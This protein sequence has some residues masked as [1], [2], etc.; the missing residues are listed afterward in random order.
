M[1]RA[2][3]AR[4]IESGWQPGDQLDSTARE[5]KRISISLGQVR[6]ELDTVA[7]PLLPSNHRRRTSR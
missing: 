1:R 3:G 2:V 6:Q 7:L 5:L 4:L